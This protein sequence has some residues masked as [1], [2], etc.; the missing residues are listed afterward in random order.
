MRLI[1]GV[2]GGGTHTRALALREDGRVVGRGESGPANHQVVGLDGSRRAVREAVA[3]A[4]AGREPDVLGACLA[5]LDLPEHEELLRVN[6][7]RDFHGLVAVENDIAAALWAVSGD[8]VGVVSSGTGA[9]IAVRRGGLVRRLLALNDV[10][11]PQ[12]GAADIAVAAL[13]AAILAAQG[14]A[15][16][17][18]LTV[19]LLAAFGAADHVALARE[20]E[21]GGLPPWRAALVAAPL[22][23]R[24]AEA[25]DAVAAAILRGT[26]R[27]LGET[28]GR[29]FRAQELAPGSPVARYGSLLRPGPPA[30]RRSFERGLRR[31]MEPGREPRGSLDAAAG[32]A[33]FAASAA[34]IAPEPLRQALGRP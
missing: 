13:R 12:G 22:C 10:T 11:G 15:P 6:L 20:S 26:G 14:A 1:V 24:L 28:A 25:G 33:L 16:A 29:F 3:A 19:E 18:R 23:A 8:S 27:N 7:Q 21:A 32:A 2:D 5:G 9:A 4:T 31:F 34:A 17:T 30:Y